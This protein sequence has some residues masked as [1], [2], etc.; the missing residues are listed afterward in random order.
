[1]KT[2]AREWLALQHSS[3]CFL[4]CSDDAGVGA[5]LAEALGDAGLLTQ[6]LPSQ[7]ALARRLAEINPALVFLDFTPDPHEPGK[8]LHSADLARTLARVSPGL[9]RVAVGLLSQPEGAV[10]ALRAGVSDFIDPGAGAYEVRDVV[11]RVMAQ[12]GAPLAAGGQRSVLLLGARPGVG[13]STLAVHLA[14]LAQDRMAGGRAAPGQE[15][16]R[17]SLD[18]ARRVAV[19]DLGWPVGDC[20]LYLNAQSDFDFIEAVNNLRRLDHTLLAS[21]MANTP[22]GIGV[23]SL[24]RDLGRMRSV[25]HADSLLLFDRLRQHYGLL[26]VDAGGFS[27]VEFIAGMVRSTQEAWLVTDQSVGS[28]VS[29]AALIRDL[30]AQEVA[31]GSLRLVVNRYDER[32]GMTAVQIA[33]RFGLELAGTLPDRT[34]ALMQSVNQG[35]LLHQDAERDPYVRAVQALARRL[36]APAAAAGTRG[37]WLSAWLPGVHRRLSLI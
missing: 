7:Q 19:L 24:P 32:Y 17:Q 10:A 18:L 26:V 30:E 4:F 33:E 27:S 6:E 37:G 23:L 13:A 12:A 9:P 1:M 29:M 34:L 36:D 22:A 31:P 35:R 2:H 25:S 5:Q 21:A 15:R 11:S 3:R 14:G 28:L 8:L 20:Q 16:D